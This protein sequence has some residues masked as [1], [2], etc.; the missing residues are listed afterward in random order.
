MIKFAINRWLFIL[1]VGILSTNCNQSERPPLEVSQ[2]IEGNTETGDSQQAEA[3]TPS[4]LT[5]SFDITGLPDVR[6]ART[7]FIME[8]K[9]SEFAGYIFKFGEADSIQCAGKNGWSTEKP[10]VERLAI[11]VSELADGFL[12]L[13]IR[14]VHEDGA[15]QSLRDATQIIWIKDVK[16][17]QGK[18]INGETI[19]AP[20]GDTTI[21][22]ANPNVLPCEEEPNTASVAGDQSRTVTVVN[23]DFDDG[24]AMIFRLY[25]LNYSDERVFYSELNPGFEITLNT[26]QTHAWV[27][28]DAN[29]TCKG[30]YVTD[31][32][33]RFVIDLHAK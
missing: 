2:Q 10:M 23:P 33:D 12:K 16:P 19:A 27:L 11:D 14:G 9:S 26:A 18:P 17:Q 3:R 20:D 7:E 31:Q 15:V 13:C 32:D 21:L 24:T 22:S 28:T 1:T 5:S 6:S 30:I 25:W 4:G 8:L 29:D